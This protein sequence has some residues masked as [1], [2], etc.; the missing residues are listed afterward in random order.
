MK[1]TLMELIVKILLFYGNGVSKRLQRTEFKD[2]QGVSWSFIPAS[3]RSGKTLGIEKLRQPE[4]ELRNIRC[5]KQ[6]TQT[7]AQSFA[8]IG[9]AFLTT[10]CARDKELEEIFYYDFW[11]DSIDVPPLLYPALRQLLNTKRSRP[12]TPC[13]FLRMV[14][15]TILNSRHLSLPSRSLAQSSK[16][17]FS[18]FGS[19]LGTGNPFV[20]LTVAQLKGRLAGW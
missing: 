16:F 20:I 13:G 5:E 17:K 11:D 2:G 8:Q 12:V 3:L 9:K 19:F 10:A 1:P 18:L 4:A 15:G 6:G 14:T 7:H